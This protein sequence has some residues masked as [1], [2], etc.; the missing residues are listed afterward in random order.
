MPSNLLDE[1]DDLSEQFRAN[2]LFAIDARGDGVLAASLR[3]PLLEQVVQTGDR[4]FI[5]FLRGLLRIDPARRLSATQA[6]QHPWLASGVFSAHR[7]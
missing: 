7:T 4:L 3:L 1:R 2:E 5:D 6:L